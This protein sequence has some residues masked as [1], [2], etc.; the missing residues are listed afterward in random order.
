[1]E[2][3]GF[4][5][6]NL[7]EGKYDRV[8]L[9]EQFAKYFASFIGDG[10]FGGKLNELQVV[11]KRQESMGVLVSSG[12][13]FLKGYWYEN[14]S[15]LSLDID[16]A[17][18]LYA[19]YDSIV[20][21]L[22]FAE[23][24]IWLMVKKG[25]PSSSP[26]RPEILRTSDYFELQLAVIKVNAG[27][28]KIEQK[29]I[30]DTR[31]SDD[32]CGL[33]SGVVDQI[34]TEDFKTQ[35]QGFLDTYMN[36]ATDRYADYTAFLQN[37]ETQGTTDLAETLKKLNELIS[38]DAVGKLTQQVEAVE[39]KADDLETG[40]EDKIEVAG[41]LEKQS[42]GGYKG[43]EQE[44]LAKL[45][46]NLMYPV[47]SI[48]FSTKNENPSTFL[49]GS[50]TAWGAGRVPVGV[51]ASQTEFSSVEKTGGEKAHT[52]IEKE[53]PKHRHQM[54]HSHTDSFTIAGGGSHTHSIGYDT[55]TSGGGA[56]ASVHKAGTSGAD[57]T[58]PTSSSGHHSHTLNGGV[59]S[60]TGTTSWTGANA[61][62]NNLQPYITCYMWKRVS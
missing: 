52:L 46:A 1:M 38:A 5:N 18:G 55:D 26:A 15:D 19:R 54:T 24:K 22:G 25:T 3:S 36:E 12:Q 56:Y 13:A 21:R 60:Y 34:S 57:G 17:D 62:H 53:M 30:I 47:G 41:F 16:I 28:I 11:S 50:W 32:E 10:I 29:D 37:L 58:S 7:V 61:E 35:L 2:N 27:V 42:A 43:Y 9:A 45:I 20:V 44:A 31:F 48:Y 14:D 51:D 49:G 23:R 40:K 8:Y 6:A 4:F 39:Q 59:N 33:V